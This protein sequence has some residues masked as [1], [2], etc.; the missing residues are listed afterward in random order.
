MAGLKY[1]FR[2]RDIV[3]PVQGKR[4]LKIEKA[5]SK[6]YGHKSHMICPT[7]FKLYKEA[8]EVKQYYICEDG[9]KFTKGEID[10][11]QDE[12]TGIIYSNKALNEFL[13]EADEKVIEI[14]DTISINDLIKYKTFLEEDYEIFSDDFKYAEIIK[15]IY[16]YLHKNNI[17]LLGKM[18]YRGMLIGVAI[19][20]S[21]NRLLLT[22]L[23]D[24]DLIKQ[25]HMDMDITITDETREKL[26][27]ISKRTKG[28][29]YMQF[30]KMVSNGEEKQIETIEKKEE[31]Q[32][33]AWLEAVA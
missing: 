31:I 19:Y 23:R 24:G 9:H 28:E 20:P 29:K 18:A 11:R 3:L 15:K 2:W 33:P 22:T 17:A 16:L 12:N 7:C 30:L 10:L 13:K 26:Y 25:S 1:S 14:K 5:Y 8:V 32:I 4:A 27:N 6:D 21:D